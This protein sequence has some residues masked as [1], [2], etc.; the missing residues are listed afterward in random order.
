MNTDFDKHEHIELYFDTLLH[1]YKT[2]KELLAK[3]RAIRYNKEKKEKEKYNEVRC[4]R[5]TSAN[6]EIKLGQ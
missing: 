6:F 3:G 1:E 5:N 4:A 2:V